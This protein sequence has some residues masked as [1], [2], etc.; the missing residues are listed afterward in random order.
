[1]KTIS[2]AFL[3][4]TLALLTACSPSKQTTEP[5]LETSAFTSQRPIPYEVEEPSDFQQAV[6]DGYRSF[7]GNPGPNYFT[8]TYSYTIN[9]ELVPADT[10]LF[11]EASISYTNNSPD[12][13]SFMLFELAQNLHKEGVP[14]KD[15]AEITGGVNIT[16]VTIGGES[17][18]GNQRSRPT[19]I[20]QGTN[21][22][23]YP[24]ERI[25]PD[26]VI[27]LEI[28]WNF[29]IPQAGASGRMGYSRKNLYFLAYWFPHVATYDDVYG[30]FGD[31]FTGNAEF[32]HDFGDYDIN[33][34]APEQWIVMST[35]AFLNPEEVLA[36]SI[37]EQYNHS[38]QSDSVVNI[39]SINDFK[40]TTNTSESGKLTWKFQA[41][42]VRD[43][44]F[45]ATLESQWDALRTPVGDIDGDGNT[46]YTQINAFW[47]ESAPL[48]E[49]SAEY[50]A[51]SIS[52]LSDYTGIEYPWPHMTSVEGAGIIGGG[53]EFPMMTVIGS[54]NIP[55]PNIPLEQKQEALYNVTAHEIAHMWIP[56]IVSSN[57][58]RYA[59]MDEG[60]TTYHEAQAR[61]DIFPDT[62]SRL[63]EFNSYLPIA[64]SYL[65][66]E[67]MRWSDYHYPGPAYGV[68]SY[69]KPASVLIALKGVLGEDVFTEAWTTFMD[70]WAYKHPT[71]Y[72]MFNTFEDVSGKDLDWFWR[73]WYFETWTL[74]QSVAGFEQ[75]G[76][77]ATITIEDFGNVVMPVDLTITF[78]DGNSM[79]TRVGVEDWMRGKR[80]TSTTIEAPS[81]ITKIEIDAD[82]YYPDTNRQNN[83][84]MK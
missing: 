47:R 10:M 33:I 5:T 17:V 65:E 72:D 3:I 32:Y 53:M 82:H 77:E 74:D 1:M 30:W 83:I 80:M 62:F 13:L 34:T 40:N 38:T 9:A 15:I 64:G 81:T 27:D 44:A 57:E 36:P 14:R 25:F 84:W 71:P 28:D 66:G 73:S 11:G 23:V 46:D 51:H 18:V 63:K 20:V 48:W 49:K 26:Q 42:Q 16:R 55:N 7:D 78:E 41:E 39:V 52:F 60:A 76:S 61:W 4:S 35:G 31:D 8:N 50:T 79:S 22:I 54:Y 43:I 19:Y 68:A 24:N 21:L 37:L 70:R 58:R 56:M 75:S 45:S 29:K 67:I 12:T 59:W 2:R 6:E 69:P